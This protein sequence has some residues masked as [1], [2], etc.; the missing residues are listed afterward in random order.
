M[1]SHMQSRSATSGVSNYGIAVDACA[2]LLSS[3]CL[4]TGG[5]GS[6]DAALA[7]SGGGA[8]LLGDSL[9]AGGVEDEKPLTRWVAGWMD[10]VGWGGVS[11]LLMALFWINAA[12]CLFCSCS[13]CCA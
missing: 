5:T 8:S 9:G 1:H 6:L 10:G 2:H 4:P 3:H 13:A 12:R 11:V 7:A